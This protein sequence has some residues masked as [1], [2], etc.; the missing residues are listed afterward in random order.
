[1]RTRRPLRSLALTLVA[2]PLLA[3]ACGGNAPEPAVG[4]ATPGPA[5]NTAATT[6]TAPSSAKAPALLSV[7]EAALD[8]TVSPCADFYA[9]ACGGWKKGTTIPEDEARWTRGF[10]TIRQQNEQ[11]LHDILEAFAKGERQGEPYAKA[12]GDF[13]GACMDEAGVE[14]AD[15]GPLKAEM[16]KVDALKSAADLPKVF[17]QLHK[18][19]VFVPFAFDSG[20]DFKDASQVI[21][22]VAQS[23]LGLPEREY[24]LK[25]DARMKELRG[26]YEEHV[27]KMFTLLGDKPDVAKK[28]AKT[29]LKFEKALAEASMKKEDLREPKKIYN[30][31]DR[32]GLKTAA[33]ALGWDGYLTDMG[34]AGVK[35]INVG[36]PDFVKAVNGMTKSVP[37]AEW[38][39]YLRWHVLRHFATE[40]P[41][42]FVD[43]QF[44]MKS[45]LT[46]AA[47][48]PPRWKRCVR[49]TD[50]FMGEALGQ[51]FVKATL[52]AEG[53]ANV[54]AMIQGIEH[55]MQ[56]NLNHLGW[57]DGTTRSRALEKLGTIA[58]K[59]AYPDKWRSYEGLTL[60]RT[61]Y[62]ANVSRA[63]GF[64]V[65]RQLKKI[66]KPLDRTE[67]QMTPPTVNAYYE[68][69]LN[70]MVFP[71]G[72]LQPPF[73]GNGRTQGVNFGGIG[74]VM[75]HELTHGFDDEGRQFDAKGNLSEWWTPA[76]NTEFEKRAS[77][78]EKQFDGY[79]VAGDAKVNGK[80]TLGENIADLGGIKLSYAA[81]KANLKKT[82]E[83]PSPSGFTPEQQFFL[84]FAQGWCSNERDEFLRLLVATNPHSPPQYRVVGPLANLKEFSEA[85][86]CKATDKMVRSEA[87]RC[88]VW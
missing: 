13:Y 34:V 18:V 39:T 45:A 32:A 76:V 75:G 47:K 12:L 1:M 44:R 16:A 33:P 81:L 37:V 83:A 2:S 3:V 79:T 28:N 43:E 42:R 52:G 29:V 80:L 72:I 20:Q 60:D 77:C 70:E 36:Q 30:R 86:S 57:M 22:Q 6:P 49:A 54:L 88:E 63:E 74:M 27:E 66:D 23:G 82:P 40:L 87:D 14:K 65:A 10:D 71:A 9:Y 19:G 8:K 56:E 15:L 24:Y 7:D 67:W 62:L 78:V 59:I 61:S 48:L 55:S 25:D 51:T 5:A 31:L 17:A 85:F 4:G 73:Y 21:G 46:G 35:S 53:K 38:K 11:T 64:E 84:G 68:P 50:A 26:K 69:T 58:N 41:Q